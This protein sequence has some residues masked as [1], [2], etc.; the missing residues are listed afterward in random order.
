MKST[1]RIKRIKNKTERVPVVF[2]TV[3]KEKICIIITRL[4][5]V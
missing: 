4:N 2:V 5:M 1:Y 3:K